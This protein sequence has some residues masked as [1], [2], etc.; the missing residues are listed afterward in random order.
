MAWNPETYNQFKSERSAPFY[1]LLALVKAKPAMTVIDLGCGTGE[2]TSKLAGTL[3]DSIVLGIDSSV[4]MLND[5]RAFANER[6]RFECRS[7]EK[8]TELGLQ[9]DLVFS[10]AA[11]QW[12]EDHE[13]LFPKIISMIRPG[14]QLLV[15][16]PA[17]NHNISNRL[18]NELA[19]TEPFQSALG[20]YA[21]DS[22][23]LGIDHYASL[24]FENGSRSMTVF[25]KI[26]PLVLK[27]SDALF[28]WVS[29]TALIP[30]AERLEGQVRTD[31]IDA[32]QHMLQAQFKKTPVFYPFRRI[33]LEATF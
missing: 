22:P 33:I 18:L 31:F 10:N 3:P 6:L 20:N 23:V 5:S 24:L 7:L 9:Y 17:Q 15:Q 16:M 2:L 13:G 19:A 21:R 29:G 32:Y 12:A 28:Q 1:D 27:D 26:Y 30:F 14:G 8:Q 4:E 11:I 25:E